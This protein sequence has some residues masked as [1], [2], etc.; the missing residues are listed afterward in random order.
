MTFG[1]ALWRTVRY[2]MADAL[3][4]RVRPR[5]LRIAV[6]KRCNSRCA[7][8]SAWQTPASAEPEIA[9]AEIHTIARAN[10]GYLRR[11]THVSLTGGE[12]TLRRDLAELV[13]AVCEAFPRATVNI[14]SNGFNPLRLLSVVNE[15][16]AYQHRRLQIMLSLDGLGEAHNCVRGVPG[17]F[18]KVVQTIN[19]L[20]ALREAGQKI[21]IEVN[22]VLT[23]QNAD[24]ML[25]VFHF[26]RERDI[27]FNPIYPVHGEL[28]A[29]DEMEIGLEREAVQKFLEAVI[30]IRKSDPSLALRELEHQLRGYPRDFD[31]WAGRTQFLIEADCSVYPNGGC[32]PSFCLGSLRD[33][34]YR[35]RALLRSPQARQV[36][37]GLRQCRLCRIPCETMTTL[38]GPEALAGY[39]KLRAPEVAPPAAGPERAPAADARLPHQPAR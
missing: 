9:P 11:V 30:E 33:F 19:R 25:P 5:K 12:P 17:V 10:R 27:E 18:P 21:S 39:R 32:P 15:A 34:D 28:Y 35:F 37:R 8:C 24:Q 36:L 1:R 2:R 23:N 14:N 13:R 16:L 26:C 4:F 22:F 6:T 3:G 29:N 31:C 20:L 38:Q 7:M